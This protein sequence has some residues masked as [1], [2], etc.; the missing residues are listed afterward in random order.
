[1]GSSPKTGWVETWLYGWAQRLVVN[2]VTPNQQLAASGA[3]P[4][5]SAEASPV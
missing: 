5:I 2:E 1:M 4:G 3:P